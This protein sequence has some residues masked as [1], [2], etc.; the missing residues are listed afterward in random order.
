MRPRPPD[1]TLVEHE[2]RDAG[3]VPFHS[4]E[5]LSRAA[6]DDRDRLVVA[7]RGNQVPLI[8]TGDRQ[9]PAREDDRP[10][11]LTIPV[12]E[13]LEAL[14]ADAPD[15]SLFRELDLLRDVPF[16]LRES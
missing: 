10:I 4:A 13:R 8:V 12:W 16:G 1:F 14:A 3:C 2:C 5:D 7:T 6:I 15:A 11:D 9:G